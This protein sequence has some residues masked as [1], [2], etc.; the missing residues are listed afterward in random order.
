[1][2]V[3]IVDFWSDGNIGDAIMQCEILEQ[4]LDVSTDVHVI[5]CFGYNQFQLNAFNESLQFDNVTWHPSF[6]NTFIKL[7][8]YI[9]RQDVRRVIRLL[10]TFSSLFL[11]NLKNRLYKL[12]KMDF[13]LGKLSYL[14][15]QSFDA[16]IFNGRNYR[17]FNSFLKNYINNQPL[18]INQDFVNN[19]FP[20]TPKLNAGF[21]TWGLDSNVKRFMSNNWNGYTENV[22][23]EKFSLSYMKEHFDFDILYR[24]DLSFDYL[25]SR[26]NISYDKNKKI[27]FSLTAV[28]DVDGYITQVNNVLEYFYNEGYEIFLIDQVYL[29]HENVDYLKELI[30]V[31]F[32]SLSSKKISRILNF[33]KE[34]ELVLSTRMHGSIMALSQGCKVAS[35]AYDDGAKWS[36]LKD[37]IFDYPIFTPVKSSSKEIINYLQSETSISHSHSFIEKITSGKQNYVSEF[38]RNIN[39]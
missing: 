27:G 32:L 38:L 18:L 12:T 31:P 14:K 13:F 29:A 37:D 26:T 33:Y 25:S 8:G 2:K 34:C 11:A 15:S 5:S 10:K 16:I 19:I 24:K 23:R 6:F 1:M 20:N 7:D 22:A 21:S 4:S 39:T 36:I 3:L 17:D 28:A 9:E 35:I 30:S